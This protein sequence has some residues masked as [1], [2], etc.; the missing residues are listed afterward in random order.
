MSVGTEPKLP[1]Y[2]LPGNLCKRGLL[3]LAVEY[4]EAKEQVRDDIWRWK[5]LRTC[6]VTV[7]LDFL[8]GS[9]VQ[10][11]SVGNGGG[12]NQS[13]NVETDRHGYRISW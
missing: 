8:G 6:I 3:F 7:E 4:S 2:P 5:A 12:W 9:H 10:E 13:K 1:N 11:Y